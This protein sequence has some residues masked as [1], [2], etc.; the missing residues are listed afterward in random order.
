VARNVIALSTKPVAG[1][2]PEFSQQFVKIPVSL[3]S[4]ITVQ[5]PVL[6]LLRVLLDIATLDLV[7]QFMHFM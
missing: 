5:T 3:N 4:A 2:C 7:T 6:T 1:L